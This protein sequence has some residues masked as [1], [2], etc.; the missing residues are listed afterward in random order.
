MN[1]VPYRSYLPTEAEPLD[2]RGRGVAAVAAM[3]VAGS[4]IA[5]GMWF[6]LVPQMYPIV[7]MLIVA[8][9]AP[10]PATALAMLISERH[11][12]QVSI[13][14]YSRFGAGLAGWAGILAVLVAASCRWQ[15]VDGL[16]EA[17]CFAL[18]SIIGGAFAT[19]LTV[20]SALLGALT[21]RAIVLSRAKQNLTRDRHARWWT[22]EEGA[23]WRS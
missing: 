12:R 3:I 6:A 22:P 5:A 4:A 19:A 17:L 20:P 1:R 14:W 10:F 8:V 16:G 21:G 13:A 9:L 7:V 11:R 23:P 15:S 18:M 2:S